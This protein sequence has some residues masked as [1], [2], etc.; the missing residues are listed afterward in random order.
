VAAALNHRIYTGDV[1]RLLPL[2]PTE[3]VN[4][5]VTSPPYWGLRDYGMEGQIG[6]EDTP[7]EFVEVIVGVMREVR[8]VL[9]R[10]GTLWMNLGDSF[11]TK[12]HGEGDT[13]DPKYPAGRARH[14]GV[15]TSANRKSY[16]RGAEECV[17]A[18]RKK[19]PG[20][21]PK[22]LVGIPWL[23]A[24][25]LQRDGW[26]LRQ[27]LIWHKTNPLPESV[28][29]RFC[30]AHEYVF[31]L[32][33]R[34]TYYFD[35]DAVK[36]PCSP[37]TRTVKTTPTKGDGTGS[38][39]EK[40]NA[41]MAANGGRYHPEM[42]KKRSVWSMATNAFPEAHFATYPPDLVR[43]CILAGCPAGGTVL[44]PFHGAGTTGVVALELGRRYVGIELNPSYVAMS[45]R[46]IAGGAR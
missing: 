20:L 37:K 1:R 30:R 19:A 3:S 7:E 15:R 13:F 21:K 9:K 29:D 2:L 6:Q 16:R 33:K 10:N 22:D 8:R 11:I 43:N 35:E 23:V 14:H 45:E 5:V 40:L 26:Y 18:R 42:R 12:P 34:E 41:W 17:P 46:R 44:D 36:E 27:D 31:L 24:F 25:A 32:S 28:K 4:C 39:G 38:T